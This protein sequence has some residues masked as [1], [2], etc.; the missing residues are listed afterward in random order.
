VFDRIIKGLLSNS[1]VQQWR[2]PYTYFDEVLRAASSRWLS[3][4]PKGLV[5]LM[6]AKYL[7]PLVMR[8]TGG[9]KEPGKDVYTRAAYNE[10]I[11]KENKNI[12]FIVYGHTHNP[13]QH[14][15]EA[16]GGHE[17]FYINSGTWRNRIHKTVSFDKAPDF[18][19][20]KQMTYS[21]FYRR[22]EDTGGKQAGT[23]S[24]DVW[25]G[26]KKKHYA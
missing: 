14:P 16:V 26:V 24:F 8:M 6:D 20:V 4:L 23:L 1:F 21:I 5:D 2:S 10:N 18:V 9:Q 11:W 17:V 25:T 13:L 7:L 19:D 22:D 12:Q 15:L 3:W